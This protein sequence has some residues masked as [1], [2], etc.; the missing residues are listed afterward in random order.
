MRVLITTV[1]Q[2]TYS[3]LRNERGEMKHLRKV[4]IRKV[5]R[6]QNQQGLRR[7]MSGCRDVSAGDVNPISPDKRGIRGKYKLQKKRMLFLLR[8]TEMTFF[9]QCEDIRHIT[10][11]PDG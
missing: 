1:V 10:S 3:L 9:H 6:P 11:E 7:G 8:K 4:L 2:H 5:R